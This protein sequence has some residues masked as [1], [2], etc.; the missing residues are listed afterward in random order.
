VNNTRINALSYCPPTASRSSA[1]NCDT[2]AVYAKTVV[3]F[4][5]ENQV[6]QIFVSQSQT[7]LRERLRSRNFTENIVRLAEDVQVTVVADRSRRPGS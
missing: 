7:R 2:S 6:T 4:A 3:E 1:G 5:R